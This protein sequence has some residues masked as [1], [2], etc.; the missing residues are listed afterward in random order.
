MEAVSD[1]PVPPELVAGSAVLADALALARDAHEGQLRKGDGSPYVSHPIT[2]AG[3]VAE[4]GHDDSVVAAAL[5]QT[6]GGEN[7]PGGR[8]GGAGAAHTAPRGAPG[9][10]LP[11]PPPPPVP[12]GGR[13]RG[14]CRRHRPFSPIRAEAFQAQR[15]RARG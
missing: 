4:A 12:L 3:L 10:P 6:G 11:P 8:P 1:T 15:A 13:R 5:L 14:G 2:V 9:G 7:R